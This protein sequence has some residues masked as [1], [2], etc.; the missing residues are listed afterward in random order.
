ME[1]AGVK[2]IQ[3]ADIGTEVLGWYQTISGTPMAQ[4]LVPE[5]PEVKY[6][7]SL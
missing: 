6:F 1:I 5:Y 3:V 4:G 7:H 2:A